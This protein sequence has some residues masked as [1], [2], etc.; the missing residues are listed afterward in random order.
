MRLRHHH[1]GRPMTVKV[2]CSNP[3]GNQVSEVPEA[4]T[5]RPG[6]CRY[7]GGPFT[8]IGPGR[9]PRLQ[10]PSVPLSTNPTDMTV[11]AIS[12]APLSR[13][14]APPPTEELEEIT[15]DSLTVTP[16]MMP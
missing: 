1:G 6:T 14:P 5:G 9:S 2:R 15:L 13:A 11:D 3:A 10:P 7:C 4:L 8:L 16:T 12:I